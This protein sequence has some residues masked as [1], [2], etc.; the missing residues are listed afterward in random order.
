MSNHHLHSSRRIRRG[1]LLTAAALLAGGALLGTGPATAE[2]A[3]TQSS[4]DTRAA[5]DR[6]RA[7]YDVLV[8]SRTAGFRHSSIPTGIAAIEKLGAEHG[9]E[10]TATE[11]PT[12]FTDEG[13]ADYEA[14]VW[15]S[16]TG[17]V[18]DEEQQGAFER[19]IQAGG[20]YVGVHAASDTEYDWPWYGG[21]VGAYFNGHPAQQ[22]ATIKVSPGL[23]PATRRLPK[24]WTRFDEWYNFRNYTRGSVRVLA[25]LDERTY[26]AG[27]TAMGHDHPIAWCH[28]YDGGRA[29]YTG[30]GHTEESYSEPEFLAHLLGGIEQVAGAAWF[31][32]WTWR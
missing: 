27:P 6:H 23:N 3:A 13:L 28:R 16:T 19:Y 22:T 32:C 10:V 15:L 4:A 30:L 1:A 20:G 29:F 5:A 11:D 25:R 18:L 26:D 24:R 17:D 9:F 8:F 21:L 7:S 14:V 2:P 31:N 12:V